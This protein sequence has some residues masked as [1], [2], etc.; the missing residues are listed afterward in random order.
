[1][2]Y[3]DY[4]SIN[5]IPE[6]ADFVAENG[7]FVAENRVTLIKAAGGVYTPNG[8]NRIAPDGDTTK[9]TYWVDLDTLEALSGDNGIT[10]ISNN[11]VYVEF[12]GY[13]YLC[14]ITGYNDRN[15]IYSCNFHIQNPE[16]Q[17]HVLQVD[18]PGDHPLF[19]AIRSEPMPVEETEPPAEEEPAVDPEA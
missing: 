6:F 8:E 14:Y 10:Y 15:I 18:L 9:T 7:P 1:M 11:L 19:A 2:A 17:I 4:T 13:R 5:D 3:G 12:E 16:N